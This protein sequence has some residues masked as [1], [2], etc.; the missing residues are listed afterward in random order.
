MPTE[1]EE[2]KSLYDTSQAVD[3]AHMTKKKKARFFF[4]RKRN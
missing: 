4:H 3:S 2:K 1:K